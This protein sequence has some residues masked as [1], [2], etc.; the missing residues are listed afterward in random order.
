[1]DRWPHQI[2]GLQAVK[3]C[4]RRGERRIL[5]TSPTG[6]GKSLI[7]RDLIDWYTDNG[8]RVSVYSNR[9]LL[10]EQLSRGL[11]AACVGHGVRAAGVVGDE[12]EAVQVSSIQTEYSRCVKRKVSELHQADLVIVDEAHLFN[13]EMSKAVLDLHYAMNAVIVGMTATP[14]GL[15]EMYHV[16]VQAGTNSA[17]RACG[18]LVPALH[19]G[20]TEPDLSKIGRIQIGEDLT[21]QQNRKA[22]MVPGIFGHV[23]EWWKRLNPEGK[24]TILFAPGVPES[25]WFAEQ[26]WKMGVPAAHIDGEEVWVNGNVV[27]SSAEARAEVLRQSRGGDVRVI[28]NRFVLREGVDAPWLNHGILATVFGSL[29]SYLQSGGRLLRSSPETDR[30]VVQDHGGNWHRHGS[31]NADRV[32]RLDDTAAIVAGRRCEQLRGGADTASQPKEPVRCPQC[33]R[34]ITSWK[35]EC[36][37]TLNPRAKSRPVVMADGTLREMRGDIFRARVHR[38]LPNTAKLW[39][40]AYW[41]AKNSKNRM[42]FNAALGLFCHEHGYYPPLTSKGMPKDPDDIYRPVASVPMERLHQ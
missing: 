6:M 23:F 16:L 21:E 25:V 5:L 32:W 14:I 11:D 24:P 1:M 20:P 36:G 27:R 13:N 28:C 19:Y 41:R 35:C 12:A 10:I 3:D 40:Q 30:V 4:I 26:F 34:I 18:A 38:E 17:G 9:K 15:E 8:K 37:L 39:A 22:I 7:A 2:A 33:A 31:L 42:T 29:Q